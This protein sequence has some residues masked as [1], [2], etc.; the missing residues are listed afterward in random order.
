MAFNF[1]PS[2]ADEI[3]KSKMKNAHELAA[4]WTHLNSKYKGEKTP[5]ALDKAKPTEA[6]VAR[7]FSYNFKIKDLQKITPSVKLAFG[8]GSRG[9]GGAANKGLGFERE[10]VED[11]N[12]LLEDGTKGPFKNPKF[13]KY[14]CKEWGLDTGQFSVEPMGALNQRRPLVFSGKNVYIGGKGDRFFVGD[15]VTDITVQTEEP[16]YISAKYGPTVTFFN[17]GVAT[18]LTPTEMKAGLVKNPNGVALLNLLGIDNVRFCATFNQYD[19]ANKVKGK[20]AGGTVN[21]TSKVDK[22]LLQDFLKSGIGWGYLLVH[23][24]G[25]NV[26]SKYMDTTTLNKA[27]VVQSVHVKYP[28]PGAAKRVD[29]FIE[30]PEFSLKINIRNKQGGLYP[31]HVMSDYKHKH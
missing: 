7:Q 10:L 21:V 23:K 1:I 18:I 29:V 16:I 28:D 25:S 31:S 11:L 22:G 20:V 6:K 30:T 8:N 17:A 12:K 27:S 13:I 14:M 24:I 5:L 15:R 3:I 9:G 4:L 26:E 2:S 19:P